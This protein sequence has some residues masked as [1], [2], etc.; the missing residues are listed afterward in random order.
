MRAGNLRNRITLQKPE[1][2][3]WNEHT[4]W[5]NQAT[6]YAEINDS[7]GSLADTAGAETHK[8]TIT[9]KI[10]YRK[11]IKGNEQVIWLNQAYAIAHVERD[12]KRRFLILTCEQEQ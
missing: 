11:Q 9:A 7:S 10:R 5:V 12:A 4:N 1:L 6:V 3:D 8:R 2:N